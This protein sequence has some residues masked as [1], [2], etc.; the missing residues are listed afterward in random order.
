MSLDVRPPHLGPVG[1]RVH[2]DPHTRLV[3]VQLAS[4]DPG[5]RHLLGEKES[6]IKETLSQSGFVLDRFQVVSQNPPAPEPVSPQGVFG[7]GTANPDTDGSG[8]FSG[9]GGSG[10][11]LS[12][13]GGGGNPDLGSLFRQGS[14]ATGQDSGSATYRDSQASEHLEREGLQNVAG[15]GPEEFFK[16]GYHRIA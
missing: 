1:V 8:G 11:G 12:M 16:T 5:I 10:T 9:Q 14:G 7:M 3:T 15:I 13:T 4:H 2:V 6:L